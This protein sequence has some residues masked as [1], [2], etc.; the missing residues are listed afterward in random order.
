MSSRRITLT[1][2]VNL[3]DIPGAF[4]TPEDA[5]A[6]IQIM[7]NQRISHYHPTVSIQKD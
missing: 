5:L 1:V 7:L 2:E 6:N 4:Y 3:D